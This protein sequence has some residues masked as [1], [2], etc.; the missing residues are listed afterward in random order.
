MPGEDHPMNDYTVNN[1]IPGWVTVDESPGSDG[2][3]EAYRFQKSSLLIA[4]YRI[5]TRQNPFQK[6]SEGKFW[7][8]TW[9]SIWRMNV[10]FL[11]GVTVPRNERK[12]D[13][14]CHNFRYVF[15]YHH[16][17]PVLAL[18][19]KVDSWYFLGRLKKIPR[20]FAEFERLSHEFDQD[21]Y[22][23]L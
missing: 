5:S 23:K 6:L 4:V 12:G 8:F 14:F 15:A 9:T 21:L 7:F 16:L 13:V 19:L 22:W 1:P 3:S 17:P 20:A 2:E 10:I 18:S 11:Y